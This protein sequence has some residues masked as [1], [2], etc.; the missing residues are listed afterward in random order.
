M[1]GQGGRPV[2]RLL[3]TSRARGWGPSEA[4]AGIA[5]LTN[6]NI[7]RHCWNKSDNGLLSRTF[8]E[9]G[10]YEDRLSDNLNVRKER[11]E[12]DK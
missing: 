3:E 8:P 9:P 11:K 7:T 5:P 10:M 12:E 4:G 2:R 1:E 6:I